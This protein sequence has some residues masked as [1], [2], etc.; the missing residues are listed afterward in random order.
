MYYRNKEI[1]VGKRVLSLFGIYI[2]FKGMVVDIW[3]SVLE[4]MVVLILVV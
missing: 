3:F 4:E 1:S 2:V